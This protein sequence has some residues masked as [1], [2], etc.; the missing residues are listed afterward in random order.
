MSIQLFVNW[1]LHDKIDRPLHP[2]KSKER[3][4]GYRA[5]LSAPRAAISYALKLLSQHRTD[6]PLYCSI[7]VGYT[8]LVKFHPCRWIF[9]G[10]HNGYCPVNNISTSLAKY[11]LYNGSMERIGLELEQ[12]VRVILRRFFFNDSPL[13][14]GQPFDHYLAI[15]PCFNSVALVTPFPDHRTFWYF[16]YTCLF[17][18]I[19]RYRIE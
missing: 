7:I 8:V 13:N 17:F 1:K 18:I 15:G 16:F 9:N 6:I 10:K 11:D 3:H 2:D 4:V 14:W 19:V 12:I 5:Q